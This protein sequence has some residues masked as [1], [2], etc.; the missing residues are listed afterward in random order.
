MRRHRFPRCDVV[1]VVVVVLLLGAVGVAHAGAQTGSGGGLGPDYGR[2]TANDMGAGTFP[3]SGLPSVQPAAISPY[4]WS[5][6]TTGGRCVVFAGPI[7][8][9]LAPDVSALPGI[10]EFPYATLQI[11]PLPV[12]RAGA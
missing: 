9:A 1:I 10:I 6:T 7:P 2:A 8:P 12:T 11:R 4:V 5:R 3:G